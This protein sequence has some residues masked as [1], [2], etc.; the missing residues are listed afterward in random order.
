M[1]MKFIEGSSWHKSC[2]REKEPGQAEGV[3]T[4]TGSCGTGMVLWDGPELRQEV[5][6]VYHCID[7]PL[8]PGCAQAVGVAL[9]E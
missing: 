6:P 2:G 5:W 1:C 9:G 7:Q 4:V 3:A 8:D